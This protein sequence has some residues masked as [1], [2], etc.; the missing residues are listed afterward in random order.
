M[1]ECTL[2]TTRQTADCHGRA[3]ALSYYLVKACAA[4]GRDVQYGVELRAVCGAEKSAAH[5]RG[6]TASQP[7]AQALLAFLAQGTVTPT[8]LWDV[9]QDWL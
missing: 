3:L 7:R 8:G 4:D 9:V 2:V 5:I 6:I 1:E